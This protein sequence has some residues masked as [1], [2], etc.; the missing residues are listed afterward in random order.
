MITPTEIKHYEELKDSVAFWID[1]N[2][3]LQSSSDFLKPFITAY[4]RETE[5]RVLSCQ[6]CIIDCLIWFR[7]ELKKQTELKKK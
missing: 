5:F 1:S 4:E 3:K 6:S 2:A 7:M